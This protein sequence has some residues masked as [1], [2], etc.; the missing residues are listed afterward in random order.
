MSS[1][2]HHNHHHNKHHHNGWNTSNNNE[3]YQYVTYKV[4]PQ[5][6]FQPQMYIV[7][8]PPPP[9]YHYVQYKSD[10]ED[11]RPSE[12][13]FS[14]LRFNDTGYQAQ[15]ENVDKEADEFIKLEHKKFQ[16]SRTTTY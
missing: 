5:P 12:R 13:N 14:G 10:Y 6:Q 8:P 2:N 4:E 11:V 7:S 16:W 1:A 9:T 3:D 15:E